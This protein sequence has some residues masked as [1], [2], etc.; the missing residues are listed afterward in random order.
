MVA[1]TVTDIVQIVA[2]LVAL[3]ASI[4]A[5]VIAHRDRRTQI[6]IAARDRKHQRL[7]LELEYAV[8][9]SA[10]RNRGGSTDTEESK[11]LGAEAL[12]L[13][14]VVG[15]KWVPRQW[16]RATDGMSDEEMYELLDGP[17]TPER[18]LWVK[19]KMETGLAIQNILRELYTP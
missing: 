11:R 16:D 13:A 14:A 8:R 6:E 12:A 4:V 9:L 2:V 17:E 1:M 10:N 15:K 5:L 18:P 19:D 7:L 3:G